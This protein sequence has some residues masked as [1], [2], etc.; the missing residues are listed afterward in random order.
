VGPV[1]SDELDLEAGVAIETRVNGDLRQ[2][3]ATLDFIFP[4]PVLLT[5]ITAVMTLEPGDLILTGTPAGVGP[6][7]AGDSVEVGIPG[8]GI[9]ANTF[10]PHADWIRTTR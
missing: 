1:V 9:L 7:A 10:A 8:L 3:G 2:H 5:Y 6:V 4:I